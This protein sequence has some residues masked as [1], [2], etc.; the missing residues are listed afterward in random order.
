ML[1]RRACESHSSRVR[2]PENVI[3]I[4]P[5]CTDVLSEVPGEGSSARS[6]HLLPACPGECRLK[7]FLPEAV[8]VKGAD[9]ESC[10]TQRELAR[11]ESHHC[12]Q[13]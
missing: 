11:E 8:W 10:N 12:L 1:A 7:A 4:S 2:S 13:T 3:L 9:M 5:L 6:P